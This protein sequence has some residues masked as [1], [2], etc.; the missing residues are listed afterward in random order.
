MSKSKDVEF[1]KRCL[2]LASK[3]KGKTNPNPMVGCVV[4]KKNR[5]VGQGY[6][7]K[8]GSCHAEVLALNKAGKNAHGATLYTNLEPCNNY[9]K[10]PPCTKKIIESKI[11]KVVY[12][13]ADP[14]PVNNK[15]GIKALKAAGIKIDGPLLKEEAEDLNYRYIKFMTKKIPFVSVKVAQSLDGK[16]A[17]C[18]G[19]SKWIS[20]KK[21]RNYVQKL[22]NQSDAVM[23]GVNTALKD[24]PCLIPR[25]VDKKPIKRIIVDSRLKLQ[26]DSKLFNDIKEFPLFIVTSSK[27]ALG[28]RHLYQKKGAKVILAGKDKINMLLLMRKLANQGILHVLVEGGGEIIASC[29]DAKV[30]DEI[31]LFTS[32]KIIGGRSS[33]TSVEGNGIVS[34]N[35]AIKLKDITLRRMDDDVLIYGKVNYPN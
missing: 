19:E 10:T 22:R 20:N 15:K 27:A 33:V 1:I 3:A 23:I 5:I 30:V 26:L 8:A 35:K 14:N 31:F 6:H 9:G 16:I 17:T 25:L 4:A 34:L 28:R 12:S 24:N 29:L 11:K 13:M 21:S 18:K 2:R 7:K 32:F